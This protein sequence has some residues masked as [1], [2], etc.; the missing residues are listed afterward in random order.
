MDKIYFLIKNMEKNDYSK[1]KI[2]LKK[3]KFSKEDILQME[4]LIK[5]YIDPKCHICRKCRAQIKFSLKR[6][7]NYVN[8]VDITEEPVE[9]VKEEITEEIVE[10]VEGSVKNTQVEDDEV[11]EVK[12][13]DMKASQLREICNQ[14][15]LQTS[16]EKQIMIDRIR[17][18]QNGLSEA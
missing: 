1:A 15:N 13:E 17:E 18:Y 4:E 16:R 10:Q 9:D 7:N 11:E 8:S 2:L 3:I 14:F 12:L 6:L 5:K